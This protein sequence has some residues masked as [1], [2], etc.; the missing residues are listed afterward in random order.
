MDITHDWIGD[1]RVILVLPLGDEVILHDR[2]GY[3]R[4]EIK[5]TYSTRSDE[6]LR[7]LVNKEMMSVWKLKVLDLEKK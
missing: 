4:K 7:F 5:K 2:K 1:L 3:S 6:N